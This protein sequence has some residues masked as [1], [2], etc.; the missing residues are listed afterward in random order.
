MLDQG[1]RLDAGTCVNPYC[2]GNG[3][4][5]IYKF[6][7]PWKPDQE[8]RN[9]KHLRLPRILFSSSKLNPLFAMLRQLEFL[10]V[11]IC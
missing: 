2:H 4:I 6:S 9:C 1:R 3:I 11:Y 8:S 10:S 7:S 5:F